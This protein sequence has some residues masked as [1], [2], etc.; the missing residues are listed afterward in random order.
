M[1]PSE[2]RGRL[3]DA[4]FQLFLEHGFESTTVDQIAT[5]AGVS[6]STFFR[7]FNSKEDVIFPDHD[8]TLIAIEERLSKGESEPL[9]EVCRAA[10]AVLRAYLAE[11]ER[12]QNRFKL[13]SS[14]PALREREILSAQRYQ[15]LFRRHLA[16]ANQSSDP[17]P[18][19]QEMVAEVQAAA[20]VS[21]NNHVIRRWLRGD[22]AHP[23]DEFDAMSHWLLSRNWSDDV[24]RPTTAPTNSIIVIDTSM[25]ADDVVARIRSVWPSL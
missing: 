9:V 7:N 20:V 3:A 6:R 19:E 13:T 15:R 1:D 25:K 11:G 12:A 10:K 14:V 23:L 17:R 24:V 4:A 22:T 5:A 21:G 16:A 2:V 18:Y 8:T